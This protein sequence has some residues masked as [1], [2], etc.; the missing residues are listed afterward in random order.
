MARWSQ[1]GNRIRH[2]LNP[3]AQKTITSTQMRALL[4]SIIVAQIT[5][6]SVGFTQ[7]TS[8]PAK[9]A[10]QIQREFSLPNFRFIPT[11]HSFS[12]HQNGQDGA[13]FTGEFSLKKPEIQISGTGTSLHDSVLTSPYPS[14]YAYHGKSFPCD[15]IVAEVKEGR[16]IIHLGFRAPKTTAPSPC[17]A[18]A[19]YQNNT[20]SPIK[21]GGSPELEKRLHQAYKTLQPHAND[22]LTK[23]QHN[24]LTRYEQGQLNYTAKHPKMAQLS[25]QIKALPPLKI[26]V[27]KDGSST[28]QLTSGPHTF[29]KGQFPRVLSRLAAAR[30]SFP[31]I[32]SPSS[33][34]RHRT[35]STKLLDLGF[36]KI[37]EKPSNI[38]KALGLPAATEVFSHCEQKRRLRT[39]PARVPQLQLNS[40]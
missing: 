8:Q 21:D 11:G 3:E 20:L 33:G 7:E 22:L 31:F 16:T 19:T 6:V 1:L 18:W 5:L 28:W 14:L 12:F 36:Q 13:A 32:I 39:L 26:I 30:P 4:L 2:V 37:E 24:L 10:E 23:E 9:T 15:A 40:R 29:P 38:A 17:V 25:T 34:P 27:T 35:I